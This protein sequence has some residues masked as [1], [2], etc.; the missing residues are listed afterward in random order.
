MPPSHDERHHPS[1]KRNRAFISAEIVKWLGQDARDQHLL[2]VASGTGCHAEVFAQQL[3]SCTIQPTEYDEARLPDILAT[4]DE[5]N[6][7]NIRPPIVLD[8][9]SDPGTWPSPTTGAGSRLWDAVM[10]S[11][12]IHISP[13]ECT[14]GLLKG[15]SAGLRMGGH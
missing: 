13:Q 9:C 7:S 15:A 12:M 2:E 6:Y 10:C 8:V 1:A 14:S 5:G 3:P 4:I 11:N